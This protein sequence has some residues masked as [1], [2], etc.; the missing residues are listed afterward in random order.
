MGGAGIK[1]RGF[2]RKKWVGQGYRGVVSAGRSGWGSD[3]GVWLQEK[4][5]G[6]VGVK[7][8]GFSD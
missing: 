8:R 1:G 6:G 5:V 7:G 3:K 2:S 4:E